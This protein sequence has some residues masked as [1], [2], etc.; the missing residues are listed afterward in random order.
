M[1]QTSDSGTQGG[2]RPAQNKRN[3]A[4]YR[5]LSGIERGAAISAFRLVTS[6]SP[7]PDFAASRLWSH[8][9]EG[10]IR[11][12]NADAGV[13]MNS[14]N[15][16]EWIAALLICWVSLTVID[17]PSDGATWCNVRPPATR[18]PASTTTTGQD[19]RS[20]AIVRDM[21]LHD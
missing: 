16:L 15:I 11:P 2:S 4:G 21:K 5:P 20:E 7:K 6:V 3:A 10:T 14:S 13:P 18:A 9:G 12:D 8:S 19:S 17:R 1:L